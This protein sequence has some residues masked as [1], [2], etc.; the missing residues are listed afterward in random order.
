M[1]KPVE[2]L[3]GWT[4][5]NMPFCFSWAN[6]AWARSWS[7]IKD[8]DAWMPKLDKKIEATNSGVLMEQDYGDEEQW[9]KHFNYL[10]PFFADKRYIKKEKK[11]VFM[12][13]E[14]GIIPCLKAMVD[15][16][17]QWAKEAGL[18]GMYFIGAHCNPYDKDILD[19]VLCHE[20]AHLLSEVP[21]LKKL[22]NE[23]FRVNYDEAWN[24]L[25]NYRG[26]DKKTY[27]GGFVTYDDT[28]RRG[29]EGIVFCDAT[30]DKFKNYFS[31]LLAKN[32]VEE[33]E[34][35]FL[36]AWN[37][38]GEG[39]YLE[40]DERNKYEYL[41]AVLHSRKHY[42]DYIE[43]YKNKQSEQFAWGKYNYLR[44]K[45]LRVD[46]Y[47]KILDRWLTLEE[48]GIKLTEYFEKEGIKSIAIYG[49]GILGKHLLKE[50]NQSSIEVKYCIDRNVDN[51]F[52][53]CSLV[54]PDEEMQEVDAVVITVTNEFREI[55][56]LLKKKGFNNCIS[57]EKVIF[58][59]N[60]IGI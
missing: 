11:P 41:E 19:A 16:W 40:P 57:L 35:V 29:K 26:D 36:N 22:K 2:Q 39:M 60:E 3:L 53:E 14:P 12:L 56:D 49:M 13:Y 58:D 24:Y 45:K 27:Y 7:K 18:E 43:K 21:A 8:A 4:D 42:R 44:Q 20:P 46:N 5:I 9:R 23:P 15:K 51:I 1:E 50:L 52:I 25:L 59:G 48:N 32:Y 17:N 38:W 10:L 34:F 47:L 31:E 55:S 28:P 30:P 54:S 33:N 37:E 6:A